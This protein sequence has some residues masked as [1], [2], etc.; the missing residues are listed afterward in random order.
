MFVYEAYLPHSSGILQFCQSPF[1]HRQHYSIL[2][3]YSN[4]GGGAQ[5][6]EYHSTF[7]A[8]SRAYRGGAFLHSLLRVFHLEEVAIR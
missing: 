4:L 3:A 6:L 2:P 7:I 5:Q 1:L 8:F